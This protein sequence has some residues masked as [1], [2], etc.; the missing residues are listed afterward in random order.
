[1]VAA[2]T[3]GELEPVCVMG[4]PHFCEND[5]KAAARFDH[6]PKILRDDTFDDPVTTA[7]KELSDRHAHQNLWLQHHDFGTS[8]ANG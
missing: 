1:V 8:I 7:T 6:A 4:Q 2:K 5:I 3:S